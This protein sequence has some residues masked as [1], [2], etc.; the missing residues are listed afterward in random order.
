[1]ALYFL[2]HPRFL[3]YHFPYWPKFTGCS[4]MLNTRFCWHQIRH[5]L[6][7]KNSNLGV[8]PELQHV[9]QPVV[10]PHLRVHHRQGRLG[11]HSV[12][13]GSLEIMRSAMTLSVL[14]T[15]LRY[16]EWK[17]V[18]ELMVA[19]WNKMHFPKGQT[20]NDNSSEQHLYLI[21]GPRTVLKA[22]LYL[23]LHPY[24]RPLQA[25]RNFDVFVSE[26]RGPDG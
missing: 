3:I 8:T 19:P 9:R 11:R 1:M 2:Y 26:R 14:P 25:T 23:P 13:V 15:L 4:I 5:F 10:Q 22:L 21:R 16:L 18:S 12:G 17:V 20:E 7:P 24:H 6:P